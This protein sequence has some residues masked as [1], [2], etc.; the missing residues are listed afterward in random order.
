MVPLG[1]NSRSE[2]NPYKSRHLWG[3]A[4]IWC[5]RR[6][7]DPRPS[8]PEPDA[9]SP[10]LRARIQTVREKGCGR[11]QLSYTC[12]YGRQKNYHQRR[13]YGCW[14][15]YSQTLSCRRCTC[16]Y[17]R[18]TRRAAGP[19]RRAISPDRPAR[20]AENDGPRWPR[21]ACAA[22]DRTSSPRTSS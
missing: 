11:K 5:A 2:S 14:S 19:A 10:E 15:S 22:A 16:F 20:G 17:L 8:G 3:P 13:N 12:N 4:F 9:L 7:S 21:S 18:P 1:F 6:E